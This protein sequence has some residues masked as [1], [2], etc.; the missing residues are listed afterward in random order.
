MIDRKTTGRPRPPWKP[1]TYNFIFGSLRPLLPP[2]WLAG[3]VASAAPKRISGLFEL[4]S[5]TVIKMT[6]RLAVAA[7]AVVA[8]V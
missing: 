1:P 4:A 8:L 5:G 6:I 7:A 2:S 3:A